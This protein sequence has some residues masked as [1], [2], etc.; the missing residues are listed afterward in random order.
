MHVMVRRLGRPLSTLLLLTLLLQLN[1]LQLELLL[2]KLIL[3]PTKVGLLRC[4]I[5]ILL[6]KQC[7]HVRDHE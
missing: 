2:S 4:Q 5:V 1:L 7:L 3:L 6:Y